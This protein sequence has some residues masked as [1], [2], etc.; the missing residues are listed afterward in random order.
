MEATLIEE[1]VR[2]AERKAIA[3]RLEEDAATIARFVETPEAAVR[4]V[5]L[6]LR[7]DGSR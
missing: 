4:I 5:A 2:R 1:T 3:D 6:M 7:L